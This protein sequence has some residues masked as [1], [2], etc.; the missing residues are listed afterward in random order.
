MIK[1]LRLVGR[2]M[3]KTSHFALMIYDDGIDLQLRSL[4]KINWT[5]AGEDFGLIIMRSI[6]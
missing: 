6:S 3:T 1:R 4:F 5:F 2:G